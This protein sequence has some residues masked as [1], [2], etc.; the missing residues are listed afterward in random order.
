[1][2]SSSKPICSGYVRSEDL[3]RKMV[4]ALLG[5]TTS[6]LSSTTTA[7]LN[8]DTKVVEM[9]NLLLPY[10]PSEMKSHPVSSDVNQPKIDDPHLVASIDENVGLN[11]SLF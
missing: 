8:G 11:L 10:P 2:N 4:G 9:R 6:G 1:M 5:F 3:L 7:W